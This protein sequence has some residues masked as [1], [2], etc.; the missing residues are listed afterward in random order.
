MA[1]LQAMV[2]LRRYAS[3]SSD[4]ISRLCDPL[5]QF[6]AQT[7]SWYFIEATGLDEVSIF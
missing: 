1:A 2:T 4:V 5:V 7:S 6:A 3:G